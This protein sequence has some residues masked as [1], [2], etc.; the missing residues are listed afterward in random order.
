MSATVLIPAFNEADCIAETVKAAWQL[1][2]VSQVIVIDDGSSDQTAAIAHQAGALV[3]R[4]EQNQGKGA[5]LNAGAALIENKV[6][7]LLDAD[8]GKSTLEAAP[9]LPP[10]QNGQADMTIAIFPSTG[11]KAGFG[12]VKNLACKAIAQWGH[13]LQAQA[14]LSGQRALTREVLQ[15]VLPFAE[16]YGVEVALTIKAARAG[17]KIIEIPTKLTHKATGRDWHG[18]KHRGKQYFDVKH[19]LKNLKKEL[20]LK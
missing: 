5:A 18:F 12:L 10:V 2:E 16:G 6:I 7:L 8:L 11:Q 3:K 13:G 19:T 9:L 1:N 14:P 15:A 20:N 4:M 17:F